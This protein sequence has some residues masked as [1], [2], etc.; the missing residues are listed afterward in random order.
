MTMDIADRLLEVRRMRVGDI[1]AH[2]RNP[3]RH[4]QRQQE[5][6][7]E[8]LRTLGQA[9]VLKAYYSECNARNLALECDKGGFVV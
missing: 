2:A 1:A 5:A 4:P 8:T 3:K 9:D 6:L 7:R